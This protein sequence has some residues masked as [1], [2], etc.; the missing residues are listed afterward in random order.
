L[1]PS[2]V[3]AHSWHTARWQDMHRAW[4]GRSGW[5]AHELATS[6]SNAE[7]VTFPGHADGSRRERRSKKRPAR[8]STDPLPCYN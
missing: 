2:Q 1:M 6:A 4:A 7:T 3:V 8:G 5:W